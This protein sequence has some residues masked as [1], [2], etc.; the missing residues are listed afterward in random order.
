MKEQKCM[1]KDVF[2]ESTLYLMIYQFTRMKKRDN[3]QTGDKAGRRE[4]ETHDLCLLK[5]RK[6]KVNK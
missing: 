2:L 1:S 3:G 4:K 5:K 6:N